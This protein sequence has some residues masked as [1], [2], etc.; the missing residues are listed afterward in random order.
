MCGAIRSHLIYYQCH[1][2]HRTETPYGYGRGK[3]AVLEDGGRRVEIDATVDGFERTV[4]C[5]T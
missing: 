1:Y 2:Y 5:R 3:K 4:L